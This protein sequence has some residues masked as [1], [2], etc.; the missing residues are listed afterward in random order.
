MKVYLVS[1][2]RFDNNYDAAIFSTL[3]K[4]EDFAMK[5]TVIAWVEEWDVDNEDKD[6]ARLISVF[7]KDKQEYNQLRQDGIEKKIIKFGSKKTEKEKLQ[8]LCS[9]MSMS[10][11]EFIRDFSKIFSKFD[12]I[13]EAKE[14][15]KTLNNEA[16]RSI[17]MGY[18]I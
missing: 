3:E 15:F 5:S 12:S 11:N 1:K 18:F 6:S 9:Q 2:D 16:N 4:A 7:P 10:D 17:I 13:Q 8:D 14:F